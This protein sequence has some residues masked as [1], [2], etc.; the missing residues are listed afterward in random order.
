M[1]QRRCHTTT[2]VMTLP[3]NVLET[4]TKALSNNYLGRNTA[5]GN[6]G[7]SYEDLVTLI[8]LEML[9][10]LKITLLNIL[11]LAQIVSELDH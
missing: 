3:L 11:A 6:I 9:E 1:V 8:P 2:R 7:N 4:P 5:P 10:T